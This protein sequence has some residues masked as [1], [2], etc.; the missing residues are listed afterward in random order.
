MNQSDYEDL[1]RRIAQQSYGN[2]GGFNQGT[3]NQLGSATKAQRADPYK[4]QYS[5]AEVQLTNG[6]MIGMMI[7]A[8]P[9][10]GGHLTKSMASEGYLNLF[11]DSETLIIKADRVVAIKLTLM[12]TE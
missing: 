2:L 11:N 12:T 9:S 5:L 3:T 8:T 6:E 4:K 10:L 1:K 7:T